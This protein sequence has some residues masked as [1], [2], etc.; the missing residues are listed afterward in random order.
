MQIDM[1]IDGESK[2]ERKRFLKA[3]GIILWTTLIGISI[4][5]ASQALVMAR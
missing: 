1:Y 4:V 5:L 3:V 2:Q